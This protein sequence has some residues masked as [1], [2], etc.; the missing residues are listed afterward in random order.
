MKKFKVFV[1]GN[2]YLLREIGKLPRKCGFYTTAFIE[3]VN[4]EQAEAAAVEL[5]KIDSKLSQNCE[6]RISDPPIIKAESVD[7]IESFDECCLP[8]MGLAFFEEGT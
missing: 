5:L 3:A 6:N 1:K 4:A 8:R 7:E 2:N